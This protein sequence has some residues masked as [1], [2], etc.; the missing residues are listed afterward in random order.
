TGK[1]L[2][3]RWYKLTSSSTTRDWVEALAQRRPP[4]L[5]VIGGGNSHSALELAR[6]MKRVCATLPE[7]S[8]PL[9]LLT[10]GTV[11]HASASDESASE[12]TEMELNDLYPDRTFRF[13]FTN[14]QMA[15]ITTRFLWE[16][17]ELRPEADPVFQIAWNDDS[18]SSD[19]L[20][21]YQYA[22]R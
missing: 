1:R 15:F 3:F 4:P 16:H 20:I 17:D 8:R 5:A 21:G 9:L 14:R 2:V 19:L 22:Q 10:T 6:Q 13:C 7:D 12:A 11:D 18:Y